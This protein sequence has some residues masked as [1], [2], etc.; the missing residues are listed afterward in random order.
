M[1]TTLSRGA[2][3]ASARGQLVDE[4]AG[5]A[6]DEGS[7]EVTYR[8]GTWTDTGYWFAR[9]NLWML[10]TIDTNRWWTAFGLGWPFEERQN[11]AVEINSPLEGIDRHIAGAFARDSLGR[12]FILHR[13]NL[14]HS[15][16]F[17]K[18]DFLQYLGH[19]QLVEVQDDDQISELVLVGML[20][21]EFLPD[22]IATF[23]KAAHIFK[24][25]L[26]ETGESPTSPPDEDLFEGDDT[27]GFNPEPIDDGDRKPIPPTVIQ[28]RHGLVVRAL[29]Q[30]VR[31]A[32][33]LPHNDK[34]RDL[35]VNDER[36]R[37]RVLFEVKVEAT[38]QAV[39]TAIGQLLFHGAE[40]RAKV[41]VAVLPAPLSKALRAR[42]LRLDV[43]CVEWR[44][45]ENRY[46]FGGLIKALKV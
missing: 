35:W 11:I 34:G 42:L 3:I 26:R 40:P 45:A 29:A 2:E 5:A 22:E 10:P 12:I 44:M 6:S 38:S 13:G 1:L 17:R 30:K 15:R 7:I 20:G 43:Q 41:R 23:V 28:R 8:G 25:I 21:A 31:E 14:I 24:E 36:G 39:Y 18:Q 4:L 19:E 46:E 33:F 37:M 16:G 32:G 27:S 9:S